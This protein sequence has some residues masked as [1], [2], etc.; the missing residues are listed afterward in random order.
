MEHDR[1]LRD[2]Q[3]RDEVVREGN[4]MAALKA[5]LE[6]AELLAKVSAWA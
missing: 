3:R 5:R 6:E 2:M 4:L 1:A